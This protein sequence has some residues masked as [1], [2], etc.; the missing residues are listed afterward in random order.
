VR[1]LAGFNRQFT[2]RLIGAVCVTVP[3]VPVMISVYVPREDAGFAEIVSVE[4]PLAVAGLFENVAVTLEGKPAMLSV[5]ELL[6][7]MAVNV[8]VTEL[9]DLRLTLIEGG[10]EIEKSVA[11]A[12][13][14][15][16][17]MAL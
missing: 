15:T 1:L 17:N 16:A 3:L 12:F 9:L 4:V 2:V 14:V 10:A 13:T 6:F 5:T 7:P 11:V 8:T